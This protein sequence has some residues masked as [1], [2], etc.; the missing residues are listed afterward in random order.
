MSG[1]RAGIRLGADDLE[2]VASCEDWGY[3]SIWAAEGQGKTAFGKLERWAS[4][5]SEIRL[6]AGIVNVFAQ[7]P[8]KIAQDVV[9]LEEHAGCRAVLGLGTA[10]PGVVEEFHGAT[11]E[12]PL[13][14]MAEYIE[15]IRRYLQEEEGGYDGEFFSPDRTSFWG[16]TPYS[17]SPPRPDVPIYN[18]AVGP[19]NVRLTGEYADGWL[20]HLVPLDRFPEAMEWLAEGAKRAGRTTDDV[21]VAMYI[22]VGVADDPTL[23]RE[24][25]ALQ[26]VDYFRGVPGFFDRMAEGTRLE[27]LLEAVAAADPK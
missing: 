9:T 17:L 16:G 13:A 2:L 18:A 25:A 19:G 1:D 23:A 22:P 26:V 14:R 11:F 4:A 5:T 27:V 12:R 24:R 6:A 3:D 21:D 10:H 7:T 15:L 20:P 8:A